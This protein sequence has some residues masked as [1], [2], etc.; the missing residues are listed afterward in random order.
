MNTH[1]I[2]LID[3]MGDTYN[4]SICLH[5]SIYSKNYAYEY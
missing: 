4:M 3:E 2:V 1:L 5:V